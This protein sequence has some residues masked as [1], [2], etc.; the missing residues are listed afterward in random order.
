M[1]R[2]YLVYNPLAGRYPSWMLT[3]RAANVLRKHGWHVHIEKPK[4]SNELS[5]LAYQAGKEQ[6]DAFFV[7][8]GDGSIN[9]SLNGLIGTQTALGVLPAGTANV[10]AQELGLPGLTWTRLMALEE[11]AHRLANARVFDMDVGICNG[12]PFLL[13]AGV[14][15]D[16]FVVNHI[17]PRS[18]LEKNFAFVQYATSAVWTAS[19]WQGM[20]LILVDQDSKVSG[21]FLLA[22]VSNIHL[23]AGG[24]AELS[25]N[26]RLDDGILELWLFEGKTLGETVQQAWDLFA[27]RHLQSGR[28]RKY[29]ISRIRL[30]SD[31]PMYLQV[32]GE[33]GKEEGECIFEVRSRALRVLVP[34]NTPRSLFAYPPKTL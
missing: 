4:D 31:S 1:L 8:G 10:W 33:P 27:G 7:V 26:A 30:E 34:E 6:M 12:T 11:S 5:K 14:G 25:P 15:L 21:H 16:G 29:E 9:C 24:L 17:E 13:W 20:D 18:R 22:V 3:E 32:D 2:A 19:K 28:V 23:Y